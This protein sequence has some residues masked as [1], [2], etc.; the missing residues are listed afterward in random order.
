[1]GRD[2]STMNLYLSTSHENYSVTFFNSPINDSKIYYDAP[3]CIIVTAKEF[4]RKSN[5]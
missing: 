3:V 5:Q 2:D 1:M 4:E